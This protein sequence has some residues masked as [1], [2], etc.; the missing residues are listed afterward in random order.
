MS[1]ERSERTLDAAKRF[2]KIMP[3][4]RRDET[5]QLGCFVVS[6]LGFD[7]RARLVQHDSAQIVRG[8]PATWQ[9]GTLSD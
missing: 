8:R 1:G 7:L 4:E 5:A 6:D 2:R 3:P 9:T